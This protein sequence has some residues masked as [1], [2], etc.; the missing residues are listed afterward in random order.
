M[1]AE[2]IAGRRVGYMKP[3]QLFV[4]SSVLFYFFLPTTTAHF[5]G[6]RDLIVGYEKH[7]YVMNIFQYDFGN[8]FAEK[9]AMSNTDTETL[10]TEIMELAAE[11]SKTWL[12]LLI[13]LWGAFIFLFFRQKIPWLVP[14]LMF[15]MHAL[16]FYILLD[17]SIHPVL[18]VLDITKGG[19]HIFQFLMLFFPVY[20]ALAARR[21]YGDSWPITIFKTMGI[22]AGFTVLILMYRQVVTI[23]V[24]AT[25]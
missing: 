15:A 14:H 8:A 9:V 21:V 3:L 11:R 12:F 6:P 20:Q 17:L 24:L 19:K 13:P 16:T 1:T 10:E 4:V 18:Y 7:D 2:W 25:L 23:S 22:A 5:T